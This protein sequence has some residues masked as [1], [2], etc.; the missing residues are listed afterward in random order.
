MPHMT[1]SFRNTF[2]VGPVGFQC[3]PKRLAGIVEPR[4]DFSKK[5]LTSQHKIL[6]FAII[7]PVFCD[8]DDAHLT[9]RFD[10]L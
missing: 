9:S 8:D 3:H 6:T 7:L 2:L 1:L 4:S 5:K 10:D